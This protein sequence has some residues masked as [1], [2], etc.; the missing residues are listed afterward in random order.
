MQASTGKD[1]EGSERGL[2]QYVLEFTQGF[3]TKLQNTR[4]TPAASATVNCVVTAATTIS[5]TQRQL[6]HF[7]VHFRYLPRHVLV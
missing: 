1:Q 7:R 4:Q 3:C 6:H 2:F 5:A